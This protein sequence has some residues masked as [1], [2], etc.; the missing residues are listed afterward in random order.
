M[1]GPLAVPDSQSANGGQLI[2]EGDH[3]S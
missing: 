3:D 1:P 2:E